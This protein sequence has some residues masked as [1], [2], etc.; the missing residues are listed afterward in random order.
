MVRMRRRIKTTKFNFFPCIFYALGV[1]GGMREFCFI[2]AF[3]LMFDCIYLFSLFLS[4]L[5]LKM[6]M[7]RVREEDKTMEQDGRGGVPSL[8]PSSSSSSLVSA[9]DDS[10]TNSSVSGGKRST[11]PIPHQ[12]PTLLSEDLFCQS[13]TVPLKKSK[14]AVNA[15]F[16]SRTKLV[17][18]SF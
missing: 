8:T 18:V 14:D 6:E 16:I 5:T 9:A 1:A 7:R 2:A 12:Y 3:I 11:T 4:V 10:N 17:L 15:F 13:E